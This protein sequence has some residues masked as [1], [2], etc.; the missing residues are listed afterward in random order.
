MSGKREM[1]SALDAEASLLGTMLLYGA[2]QTAIEEGLEEEDF[3]NEVNQ[4]IFRGIRD[5]Y[6]H[7]QHVDLTTVTTWLTDMNMLEAVGGSMYLTELTEA[8]ITSAMTRTYVKLVH[9]KAIMRRMIRA[10]EQIAADGY[11][12]QTDIDQ[13]LDECEKSVLSVSRDRKAGEFKKSADLMNDAVATIRMM[14]AN[15]SDV[16]GLRTGF[17]DL[18]HMTH[19]L[20]NGD[21][22]ILAARPSIGKTAVALNLAEH[23]ASTNPRGAVAIFSLE[24]TAEQLS[25]R[26]LS[27]KSKVESGKLR[28]GRLRQD[29]W[30]Q[31]TEA[32]SDLKAEKIYIDDKP[33]IKVSEI[34]SKCRRLKNEV[35]L[36]LIL[37][38][39]LQLIEGSGKR[40]SDNRQQE[41]SEISRNLKGLAREMEVPVIALSQLS[42]SV[43]QRENKRPILSD[44]RE[45]GSIEQDADIVMML[46]RESYYDDKLKEAVKESGTERLEIN[47]AKQRNG[48]IGRIFLGF[49]AATNALFT[50]QTAE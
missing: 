15:H 14:E 31:V 20:Q 13:Y 42:R 2:T 46:Y 19:G 33:G 5:L 18:D 35:G 26:F 22:I 9:D 12:G 38:D 25:M 49:E 37:I 24:M 44:L 21:L 32:A 10:A 1:P 30:N 11:E 16:T 3:Y 47:I 4:K 7:G 28:T 39:Y 34:F 17:V 45:S 40:S 48:A 27:M 36:S 41:I 43:E 6:D 8:A 50:I 29:E 23:V